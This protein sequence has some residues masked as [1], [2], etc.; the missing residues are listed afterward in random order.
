MSDV[1]LAVMEA[2]PAQI[3]PE[4]FKVACSTC[5]LRH[6]CLPTGLSPLDVEQLESAVIERRQVP[7]T[8]SLYQAGDV[9]EAIFVVRAGVFKT[10]VQGA[11]SRGRDQITAFHMT[12]ELLGLDGLFSGRHTSY[13][14]ALE[15]SQVCVIHYAS[16]LPLARTMDTLQHQV[17]RLMSREIVRDQDVM[18]MRGAIRSEERV[19][20]FLLNLM[21]RL[22]S[23]GFSASSMVMRMT[24]E[25]IGSHLGMTLETV[26]RA[27]SRLQDNGVIEVK[28]R[29]VRVLNAR[30]LY[31]IVRGQMMLA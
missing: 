25:E 22:R 2:P 6:L 10:L 31:R 26:S 9:F 21:K 3:Q 8:L 11:R 13:A 15:D 19:A 17:H 4:P 27:L 1:E 30:M 18:V 7:R 16:L 28:L 23:R 12:G 29:E 20:A 14:V 24:R 5:G